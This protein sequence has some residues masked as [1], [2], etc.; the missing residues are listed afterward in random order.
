MRSWLTL[1]ERGVGVFRPAI[2]DSETPSISQTNQARPMSEMPTA[3]NFA[4]SF[5]LRASQ[6][7]NADE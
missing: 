7:Q 2:R 1:A 3:A 5:F 4:A 6:R